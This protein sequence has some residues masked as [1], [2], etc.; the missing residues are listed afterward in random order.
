MDGRHDD[1][2][3]ATD[4]ERGRRAPRPLNA[5]QLNELAL[6]YVARFATSAGRL[7]AYLKR[8]LRERGWEGEGD[9]AAGP[10]RAGVVARMVELGYVDDR[11]FAQARAGGMLRRGFGAR[12]I[13]ETLA[14][15]G[16]AQ[17]I[18][19]EARGSERDARAAAVA[20]ARR[21]RLGPFGR[22][23]A[24]MM[25]DRPLRDKQLAAMLRA[26]HTAAMARR[27]IEATDAAA[28]EQWVD[29]EDA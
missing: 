17:D 27:V 28:L 22:G 6:A 15:D 23:S 13:S 2:E 9:G 29:D 16:I 14:R 8:K 11:G 26:G 7:D 4:R 24:G 3:N 10:D 25:M 20:F 18:V 19:A 1:G 21:R 12:R 5:R